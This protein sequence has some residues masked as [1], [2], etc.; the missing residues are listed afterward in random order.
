MRFYRSLFMALLVIAVMSCTQTISAEETVPRLLNFQGRVAV[1]GQ[2][3]TGT[4]QF[5]FALVDA[6]G[7]TTYWSNDGSSVNA[8]EPASGLAVLVR[9]GIYNIVLGGDGMN[10]IPDTL[11]TDHGD[12][13]LRVW[14]NDTTHG[15]QHL[16]PDQQIFP[17]GYALRAAV[18]DKVKDSSRIVIT[19]ELDSRL[20]GD[21]Y[22]DILLFRD[23][24]Y[25]Y[26]WYE[27]QIYGRFAKINIPVANLD[28]DDMPL[29]NIYWGSA[30]DSDAWFNDIP[31]LAMDEYGKTILD[32]HFQY[33]SQ[34][35]TYKIQD[36]VIQL[37]Y[38]HLMDRD[39]PNSTPFLSYIAGSPSYNVFYKIVIMK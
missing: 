6:S 19:G 30:E 34:Y 32:L 12:V 20:Q 8:G 1:D 35:V 24:Y 16:A 17:V 11:F 25:S 21:E 36:G 3:F 28:I 7:T 29:V 14:F 22:K 10:P 37:S 39:D 23:L 5:K 33:F 15:F 31:S 4:G 27:K 13:H 18:A 26:G 2:S 38:P 9:D